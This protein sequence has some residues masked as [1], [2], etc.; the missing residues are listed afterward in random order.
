MNDVTRARCPSRLPL[1]THTLIHIP[2]KK[3]T[4]ETSG[5]LEVKGDATC[6]RLSLRERDTCLQSLGRWSEKGGYVY[7]KMYK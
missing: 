5:V 1:L 4:Q 3:G 6:T 2:N 7:H